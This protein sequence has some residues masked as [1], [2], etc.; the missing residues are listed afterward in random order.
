MQNNKNNNWKIAVVEWPLQALGSYDNF[1]LQ[2]RD[3]THS[4]VVLID[5]KDNIIEELHGRPYNARKGLIENYTA[6]TLSQVFNVARS[7]KN[8]PIQTK[9]N[10]RLRVFHLNA[11]NSEFFSTKGAEFSVALTGT[12]DDILKK[13]GK[14]L[15]RAKDINDGDYDYIAI[16]IARDKLGQ[17]CH[18]VTSD[19]LDAAGAEPHYL[20]SLHQD[21]YCRP[22]GL[23][24]IIQTITDD[25]DKVCAAID[26]SVCKIREALSARAIHEKALGGKQHFEAD[27][28]VS[29]LSFSGFIQ[30]MRS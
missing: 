15:E 30:R 23:R 12:R 18:S 21:K 26:K 8:A 25:T 11:R 27:T 1:F 24:T 9:N 6:I 7:K 22:G 2:G 28:K 13:W 29:R 19:L 17:N 4:G 14:C 5:D 3:I 16:G 20:S 10:D